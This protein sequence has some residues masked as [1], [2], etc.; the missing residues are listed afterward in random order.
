MSS[1]NVALVERLLAIGARDAKQI[2]GIIWLSDFSP[3]A[4]RG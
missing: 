1:T 2:D 3:D 4:G